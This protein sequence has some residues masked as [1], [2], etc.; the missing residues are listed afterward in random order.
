MRGRAE[1]RSHTRQVE[2]DP[3]AA[4]L[5]GMGPLATSA[6]VLAAALFA[7]CS[8]NVSQ[9]PAPT[10]TTDAAV[11][12]Q[13]TE[14]VVDGQVVTLQVGHCFIEPIEVAGMSW[15]SRRTYVGYGGGLPRG[16]TPRG[17]F[18]VEDTARAKFVADGGGEIAFKPAPPRTPLLGCR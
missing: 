1:I 7:G 15:V 2:P 16:F 10:R 5:S 6:L 8:A 14:T 13:A 11:A 12:E 3:R 4:R 17:V 9:T 18:V